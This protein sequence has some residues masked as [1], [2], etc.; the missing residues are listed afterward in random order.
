MLSLR[1]LPTDTKRTRPCLARPQVETVDQQPALLHTVCRSYIAHSRCSLGDAR[2]A[3]SA[4]QPAQQTWP[5]TNKT[6]QAAVGGASYPAPAIS[7]PITR[8]EARRRRL[9]W[10]AIC[11]PLPGSCWSQK[12]ASNAQAT[13]T[14]PSATCSGTCHVQARPG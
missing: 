11:Q 3:L 13:R 8:S 9:G 7:T 12:Q 6:E 10:F 4:I 14:G 2:R 5:D 1:Y